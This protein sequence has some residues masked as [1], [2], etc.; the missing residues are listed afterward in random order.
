MVSDAESFVKACRKLDDFTFDCA[1]DDDDDNH[2]EGVQVLSSRCS[3]EII[4][5]KSKFREP[6]ATHFRNIL[7]N[8]KMTREVVRSRKM[9]SSEDMHREAEQEER[10]EANIRLEHGVAA[11]EE[12]GKLRAR[13][14]KKNK[15][16][17][18]NTFSTFVEVQLHLEPVFELNEASHAH[19]YHEYFRSALAAMY[20]TDTG[21]GTH[22]DDFLVDK[23]IQL[24][25]EQCR[26]PMLLSLVIMC[27]KMSNDKPASATLA[28]V[29]PENVYGLY[30]YATR[31]Y[32]PYETP[33]TSL[34]IGIQ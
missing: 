7:F 24:L 17:W 2:G 23:R 18:T 19:H 34:V 6:D 4:R 8:L 20:N 11:D 10:A 26:A 30:Q 27:M 5:A 28:D 29:L 33:D 21:I 3:V 14:A 32:G 31:A 16:K 15:R 25:Q 12:I 22:L 13:N 1:P 9:Q